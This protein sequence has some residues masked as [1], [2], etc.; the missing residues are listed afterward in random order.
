MPVKKRKADGNGAT[1]SSRRGVTHPPFE[2]FL[3]F[4]R[5]AVLH[6]TVGAWTYFF[7]PHGQTAASEAEYIIHDHRGALRVRN[8]APGDRFHVEGV[9][10]SKWYNG[11]YQRTFV[12]SGD[13][14]QLR[15][16]MP[17]TSPEVAPSTGTMEPTV[18]VP[19]PTG[20]AIVVPV[21]E[22][23]EPAFDWDELE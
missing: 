22:I 18:E 14:A 10:Q 19:P 9:C 12:W 17:P 20:T 11:V 2:G 16:R 3:T 15:V 1:Q 23:E 21:P 5:K 7:R 8:A 4:E 13:Q 6:D